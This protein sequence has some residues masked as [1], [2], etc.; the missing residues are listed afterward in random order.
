MKNPFPLI[1]PPCQRLLRVLALAVLALAGNASGAESRKAKNLPPPA[2][3][4]PPPA[5][6]VIAPAKIVYPSPTNSTEPKTFWEEPGFVQRF[7]GSYGFHS[8]IEPKFTGTNEQAFFRELAPLIRESPAEAIHRLETNLTQESSAILNFTLA[9]LYFQ[10]G[11]NQAAIKNYETALAKFPEFRRAHKNLGLALARE[12]RYAEALGPLTKTIEMGGADGNTYGLLGFAY[13]NLGKHSTAEAAYRQ[14]LLLMPEVTDWKL[15]LLKCHVAQ[16][17]HHEAIALV[18]ELLAA[19]PNSDHLWS[20]QAGVY[21]QMDQPQQAALNYEIIRKLGKATPAHLMMLGDIY[22]TQN[23]RE[24]A[25]HAYLEAVE[26]E[27]AQNRARALRAADILV[28]RG[29]WEE[30]TTLLKRLKEVAREQ[31]AGDEELKVLK[32]ES[33]VA[34]ATGRGEEAVRVLEQIIEKN[35]LDGEAQLLAG[36][37]YARN[38]MAEKADFRFETASRISGFEAD[39]YVKQAQLLAK[40]QKYAR[41]IDLLQKAQKLKPRDNVQR[42]LQAIEKLSR[43]GGAQSGAKS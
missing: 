24:L 34:M 4:S 37:Y 30:A 39:A 8:E 3:A 9:T 13:L 36:D 15:G 22:M 38:G 1:V 23:A 7:M 2:P 12:G 6:V 26:K 31:L 5:A 32:L 40:Q 11:S 18:D 25:L 10:I 42:Y 16:G 17:R 21:L 43:A 33:K 19:N 27:G 14:A 29:A 41:A 35:P 28:S 20:L